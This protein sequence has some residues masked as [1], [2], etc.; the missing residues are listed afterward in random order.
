MDPELFRRATELFAA[1]RRLPAADRPQYLDSAC[2]G[3]DRL[4]AEVESLLANHDEVSDEASDDASVRFEDDVPPPGSTAPVP[5]FLTGAVPDRIGS[6]RILDVLGEGGM[7]VVYLAEQTE[8]V[9][10]RA[11]LKVI[12]LGMD[13]REV[14]GR[15]EAERQA[16][17]LMDHPNIARIYDA[18]ATEDGRPYFIMEHV[19]GVPITEYCD[20]H[21]L[22]VSDRLKLFVQVCL[23]VQHAHLRGVIHRDIKPSNILVSCPQDAPV[24]KVIDFGVAKATNQRLTEKTFHTQIG[25]AIGTPAY[26]SPEQAEMTAED[27]DSR[28]DVYSLGV[29]LYELSVGE[30]P[31]EFET[32]RLAYDEILRRIR[33]DEP[34]T[35]STRLG[36]LSGKR[37]TE[38]ASQRRTRLAT[39][40]RDLRGD[41]D[42]ITMKAMEKDRERRYPTA[43]HLAEDI[44]RHLRHEAVLA[45]PPTVVYRLGKFVRKNRGAVVAVASVFLALAAGLVGSL[46]FWAESAENARQART[47]LELAREKEAEARAFAADAK[48]N[49]A[50][51]R[52]SLERAEQSLARLYVEKAKRALE[53]R[54]YQRAHVFATEALSIEDDPATRWLAYRARSEA[55]VT[56]LWT[57]PGG[58]GSVRTLAYSPDGTLLASGSGD[59]VVRLWDRETLRCV[60]AL[61]GAEQNPAVHSLAFGPDGASLVSVLAD[62]SV[63]VWDVAS[64]QAVRRLPGHPSSGFALALDPG[65]EWLARGSEDGRVLLLSLETPGEERALEGHSAAVEALA[66]QPV[67]PLLASASRDGT[68]RLWESVSGGVL[69]VLDGQ[70]GAVFAVAFLPE[71]TSL[72]SGH[73]DGTILLWDLKRREARAELAGHEGRVHALAF[74]P[75]G[76]RLASASIDGSARL[77]ETAS[78]R[79]LLALDGHQGVVHAVAFRPD[80]SELATG[81]WDQTIRL[82]D[83]VS[84]REVAR[85]SGHGQAVRS[86]AFHPEGKIVA[87]ASWDRTVQLRDAASGDLL[88]TLRGH[89]GRVHAIAFQPDGG[90]LASGGWDYTV[91]LWDV[92]SGRETRVLEG[93][94]HLVESVAFAPQGNLLASGSMDRTI[95]LWNVENGEE[96]AVL[97]NGC[98]ARGLTFLPDGE[99]LA[100]AYCNDIRLWDLATREPVATLKG[101][102]KNASCLASSP[103]GGRLASG[104]FDQ[105]V[106]IWDV[107]AKA[108]PREIAVL[109]GHTD[110]VSSV[111]FRGSGRL[112]SSSLDGTIRLWDAASGEQLAVVE[113]HEGAV[114]S[115]ALSPGGERL[116]SASGDRTVRTWEFT[117]SS[118]TTLAG[119]RGTVYSLVFSADGK[120][121][122]SGAADSRV[123]LWDVATGKRVG[124]GRHSDAVTAVTVSGDGEWLGSASL[125]GT[126][127]LWPLKGRG[128]APRRRTTGRALTAAAF[129]PRLPLLALGGSVGGA[130]LLHDVEKDR[131]ITIGGLPDSTVFSI[132]FSPDGSIVAVALGSASANIWLG[133]V[134]DKQP[135]AEL[136]G[137]SAIVSS[138]VFS[139]D[140]RRI[141]SGSHDATVRLWDLPTRKVERVLTGHG[142][143]VHC[144]AFSPDSRWLAS[145][146]ADGTVRLWDVDA[147]TELVRIETPGVDTYAVAFS[148]RVAASRLLASGSSDGAIRLHDLTLLLEEPAGSRPGVRETTGLAL[149]GTATRPA[150]THRLV[151]SALLPAR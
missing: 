72:A 116:A 143:L 19:P 3:D 115:L 145:G 29:L 121:L 62:R 16:L 123:G 77:W 60:A 89:T 135:V 70:H 7:G 40:A 47:N 91:R 141:A 119:H 27:V 146:S 65:G 112:L 108:E 53:E 94:R 57:S 92:P 51:A 125:D 85:S 97:D 25:R 59:G 32:S 34:V 56:P 133:R 111:L 136:A 42:W 26:M 122:A 37:T 43:A 8:P 102:S 24:A 36:R 74:S 45:R 4:R 2:A 117:S 61:G 76:E 99:R 48:E 110:T 44:E 98:W 73:G 144:V 103:D 140:G 69:E 64:R 130:I 30:L 14:V 126:F 21:R 71:G 67:S 9:R 96:I 41:L 148:P 113:G 10:R 31:L 88:K 127:V 150:L 106:R 23:A 137:H 93:H 66:F 80:G 90:L 138:V 17:A 68:V 147:G 105:T 129:H 128:S 151:R 139:P 1:A 86:V 95:R 11:A 28:T 63:R 38:L 20:R 101:H 142:G 84:G 5:D 118:V 6:F 83:V 81:G 55:L 52:A 22:T 134:R 109:H 120:R 54:S 79:Q 100:A 75:D 46:V 131:T 132:A 87:S 35:P 149:E 58:I 13:T 33:E 114:H 107:S 50:L 15:F 18:G 82:W 124:G 39:L 78:G 104:S 12:K 49:E